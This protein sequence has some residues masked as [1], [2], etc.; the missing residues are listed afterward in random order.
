MA[1]Y[2]LR[3]QGQVIDA[4]LQAVIDGKAGIQG[5]KI[6]RFC[7]KHRIWNWWWS[8]W[9]ELQTYIHPFQPRDYD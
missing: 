4:T 6:Q 5:V 9:M 8:L 2:K 1:K 7:K 3:F